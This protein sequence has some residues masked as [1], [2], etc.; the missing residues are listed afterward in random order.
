[1]KNLGDFIGHFTVTNDNKQS[2]FKVYFYEKGISFDEN[3]LR[4]VIEHQDIYKEFIDINNRWKSKSINRD[5]TM[6][7]I[8]EMLEK[9]QTYLSNF[10][11]DKDI[12]SSGIKD[13]NQMFL[14]FLKDN[15]MLNKITR[16]E[17]ESKIVDENVGEYYVNNLKET[18]NKSKFYSYTSKN[19]GLDFYLMIVNDKIK[20]GFSSSEQK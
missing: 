11:L 3:F 18:K 9:H 16:K 4:G 17:F 15:D 8:M 1:M 2:L 19:S 12:D 7:Y 13:S 14:E 10:F 20:I 6:K 5:G